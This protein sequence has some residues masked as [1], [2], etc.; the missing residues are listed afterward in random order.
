MKWVQST[1]LAA[2]TALAVA[3]NSWL[4][5]GAQQS[6]PTDSAKQDG[7]KQADK[8]QSGTNTGQAKSTAQAVVAL[9]YDQS[10]YISC[11][12]VRPVI[13][14]VISRYGSQ[15]QYV[16]LDI[17]ANALK[18]TRATAKEYGLSA[19]LSDSADYVPLVG[20]FN[21]KHRL[22]KELQGPKDKATY[23]AA[24]AKVL[25]TANR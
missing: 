7:A 20:I 10:C 9:V 15:V 16:E 4:P 17:S 12:K 25:A 11:Q 2:L 14:D 21:S 1:A 5:T 6:T 18:Q 22:M 3:T 19:Y 13:K 23:A 24:V 8:T